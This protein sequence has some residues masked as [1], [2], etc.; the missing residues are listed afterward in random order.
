ML[1][2]EISNLLL[3]PLHSFS[4]EAVTNYTP[5]ST[6]HAAVLMHNCK[7]RNAT[8]H[9]NKSNSDGNNCELLFSPTGEL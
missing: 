4:G 5:Q 7:I 1:P 6:E 3:Y 8:Y 9:S 2:P